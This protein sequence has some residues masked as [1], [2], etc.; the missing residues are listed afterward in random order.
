MSILSA[1]AIFTA[2]SLVQ[3]HCPMARTD[4]FL[5]L[6]LKKFE[7]ANGEGVFKIFALLLFLIFLFLFYQ[8][9]CSILMFTA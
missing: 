5:R 6:F 1:V 7:S 2:R 9:I 8:M 4:F 3:A